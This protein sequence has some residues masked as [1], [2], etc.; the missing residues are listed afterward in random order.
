MDFSTRTLNMKE[1][2]ERWPPRVAPPFFF[3]GFGEI[4]PKDFPI[5]ER[6]EL[7]EEVVDLINL[8]EMVFEIEE[9]KLA[10]GRESEMRKMPRNMIFPNI[11]TQFSDLSRTGDLLRWTGMGILRGA[12]MKFDLKEDPDGIFRVNAR[13]F[14]GDFHGR[15]SK[16]FKDGV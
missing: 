15:S 13:G 3:T 10:R 6:V 2:I 8:V 7:G 4:G 1:N 12:L 14:A 9:G 16:F 5:D 11:L